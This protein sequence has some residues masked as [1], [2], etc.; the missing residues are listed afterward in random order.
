MRSGLLLKR[1]ILL[2]LRPHI[3]KCVGPAGDYERLKTCQTAALNT[4]AGEEGF[5]S[6]VSSKEALS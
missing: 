1:E 6:D 3:I 5:D 4:D 2:R